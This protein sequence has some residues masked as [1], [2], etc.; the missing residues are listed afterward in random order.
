MSLDFAFYSPPVKTFVLVR[1]ETMKNACTPH[2]P[3]EIASVIRNLDLV[4][5]PP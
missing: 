4:E 1:A 5:G 3:G 2:A